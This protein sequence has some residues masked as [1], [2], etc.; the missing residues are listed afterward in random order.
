MRSKDK[1]QERLI[2][3]LAA[4]RAQLA[5]EKHKN[6]TIIESVSDAFM[7]LDRKACITYVNEAGAILSGMKI[8]QLL[9]ASV[10][11]LFPHAI[12]TKFKSEYDRAVQTKQPVHFEEFYPD[13]L[14]IWLE[15]HGYP[16]EEG[17]IV[18]FRDITDRKR[19]EDT[20]HQSEQRLKRSQ[21]IAHLGSWEIDLANQKHVWSDEVYRIFGLQPQQSDATY[22]AFVELTH[23]DDRAAVV[24]AYTDSLN[25]NRQAYE[26]EHRIVRKSGEIRFVYHKWEHLRD[27]NGTIIGSVG[28]I[29]DI[30]ERNMMERALKEANRRYEL[31]VAGTEAAVWDWD[32]LQ[33]KVTFSPRWKKMRGFGEHEIRDALQEWKKSIHPEDQPRVLASINAHLEGKTPNYDEEYRIRRK[34]GTWMWVAD[35]GLARRDSDGNVV[36]MAG[37]E[38]DITARKQADEALHT[39]ERRYRSLF[40]SMEA[41]ALLEPIPGSDGRPADFRYIE[42]NDAGALIRGLPSE[43][44]RGRTILELLPR[45]DLYWIEAYGQVAMTQQPVNFE[46]QNQMNKRWYRTYAYCPEEGNV[47]TLIIDITDRK[48]AEQK[49]QELTKTLEQR[50]AQR[51]ELAEARSKQL[52]ALAVE[53]IE[54]EERERQRI[55]ELL[56]E[57]LQQILAAARMQLQAVC[58]TL[59]DV[60]MLS[61]VERLLEESIYKT[62]QL[63]HEL[64][65]PAL[66]HCGLVAALDWLAGQMREQ[67]G[68]QVKLEANEE[69]QFES[70]TLK[71]F[72]F[73]AVQEL[74]FNIVKHAG[75]KNGRVVLSG[76]DKS[77]ILHVSDQG[78]G[79]DPEILDLHEKKTGLGLLSLRERVHYIGGN[80][81]IESVPGQGSRFTIAVPLSFSQAGHAQNATPSDKT[82]IRNSDM[83]ANSASTKCLR[84]L[85]ADDH[86]VMRKGLIRLVAGQPDIHLVGEAS[87]GLEALELSRRLYP[88]VVVMDI[89]MPK[90]DGIEATRRIKTEMPNIRVIG[91]SMHH[92]EQ[93]ALTMRQAGAEAFLSKTVSSGNLLSAIYGIHSIVGKN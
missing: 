22:E 17:I 45:I 61:N 14:N 60:P 11:D 63:S 15:C 76:A 21:Q 81:M 84:L 65:P 32:V 33:R 16:S 24:S 6:R 8:G 50:V 37:V 66:Y 85:F 67:F 68:L 7:A 62:R 72:L 79:F 90:M 29:H 1:S 36:Q 74:L 3:E 12:T 86:E 46:R 56:H 4:V 92:D 2:K 80:L 58:N 59:S 64:S 88:D 35:R 39:S 54:A 52:Q 57:D 44:I 89:S 49:L 9:G 83:C 69:W 30:T 41:F 82:Q 55:A 48:H 51:T 5:I 28:M 20:L 26:L 38:T 87:N 13:P 31:V 43:Q 25:E 71:M 10:W 75:V 73:R 27:A 47:A 42:I 77:L 18:F 19:A 70:P 34:D 53:L 91:L 23:P 40:Q 93:L 78:R